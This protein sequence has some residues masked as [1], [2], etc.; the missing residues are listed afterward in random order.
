MLYA[1][2]VS[3]QQGPLQAAAGSI[4]PLVFGIALLWVTGKAVGLLSEGVLTAAASITGMAETV[5]QGA[6]VAADVAGPAASAT[7]LA[8]RGTARVLRAVA[9]R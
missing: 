7:N 9:L 3:S 5:R 4:S 6:G 8:Y 2:Q 1:T